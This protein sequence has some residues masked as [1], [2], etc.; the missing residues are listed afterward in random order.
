MPKIKIPK[1]NQLGCVTCTSGMACELMIF[2]STGLA[3]NFLLL[4][5]NLSISVKS[6]Y[7]FDI[8][9]PLMYW[10]TRRCSRWGFQHIPLMHIPLKLKNSWEISETT[11]LSMLAQMAYAISWHAHSFKRAAPF[12]TDNR[13]GTFC[14][15]I[16]SSCELNAS[17]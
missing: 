13:L 3:P 16:I 2:F 12:S 9:L 10:R 4:W 14:Y 6:V 15:S 17:K 1:R 5:L 8:I 7:P 11:C